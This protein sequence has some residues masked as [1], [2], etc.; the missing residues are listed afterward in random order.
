MSKLGERR[1]RMQGK[2]GASGTH[3]APSPF[4]GSPFPSL[5]LL[6][7]SNTPHHSTTLSLSLS[8][9]S[10]YCSLLSL[11]FSPSSFPHNPSLTSPPDF[12]LNKNVKSKHS[13]VSL[14]KTAPL[15]ATF[16]LVRVLFFLYNI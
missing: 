1:E 3:A 7:L 12:F 8:T 15:T 11:S 4:P 6:P 10:H 2:K 16:I 5:P 13:S 9:T 14:R